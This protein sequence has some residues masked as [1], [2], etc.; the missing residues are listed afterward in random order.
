M[1]HGFTKRSVIRRAHDAATLPPVPAGSAGNASYFTCIDLV[2]AWAAMVTCLAAASRT[3]PRSLA[4]TTPAASAR[5]R[6][7]AS[8]RT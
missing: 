6:P 4:S 3:P 8:S 2:I 5:A 7:A 1:V